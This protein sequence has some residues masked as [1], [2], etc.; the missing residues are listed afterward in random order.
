MINIKNFDSYLLNIDKLEFKKNDAVIYNIRYIT[1]EV[2]G[3][4]NID[5]K[6]P[7]YLILIM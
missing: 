1:M 6:N 4:A 5:S 3:H 2:L 7:L